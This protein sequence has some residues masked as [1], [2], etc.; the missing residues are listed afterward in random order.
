M[1]EG[2]WNNIEEA[3]TTWRRL[4][5][6]GGTWGGGGVEENCWRSEE[7]GGRWKRLKEGG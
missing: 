4:E 1:V 7:G 5:E 3:G 6:V 2:R